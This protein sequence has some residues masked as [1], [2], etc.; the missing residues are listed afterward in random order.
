VSRQA[1]AAFLERGVGRAAYDEGSFNTLTHDTYLSLA[2]VTIDAGAAGSGGGFVVLNAST[3]ADELDAYC[4]PCP[5]D[6][7]IKD[8]SGPQSQVMSAYITTFGDPPQSTSNTWVVPIGADQTKTFT[9]RVQ[10]SFIPANAPNPAFE[11]KGSLSAV[12]VPLGPD[13]GN[14]LVYGP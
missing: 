10:A 5:I 9:L 6:T 4:A 7:F 12:Y 1:M 3:T 2:T 8:S 14:D 13:G 11:F